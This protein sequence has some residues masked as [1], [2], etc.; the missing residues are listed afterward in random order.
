MDSV[1][2]IG[3]LDLTLY[4]VTDGSGKTEAELLE[5]V[6]QACA[7]GVTLVQLREKEKSGLEYFTLAE[8]RYH[9]ILGGAM[10]SML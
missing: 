7:G 2:D 5:T 4:F 1:N 6:H 10:V 9:T 8:K 3:K